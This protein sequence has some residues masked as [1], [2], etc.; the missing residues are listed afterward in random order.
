MA[1]QFGRLT[2]QLSERTI[3]PDDRFC[4]EINRL[5]APATPLT[6]DLIYVAAKYL[7]SDQVNSFG[8]RFP[9]N[10]HSRLAELL[11]DSPV[12]VGHRKDTLPIA[13]NFRAE[14]VERG[15]ERWVKSYFYW[16]RGCQGAE[17]LKA[18]IDGGL[19]KEC[20]IAF[21]YNLPECSICG[22]DIRNCEHEPGEKYP[23]EAGDATCH[24]NY[25]QIERVL[26]SSLVYRGAVPNT[27]VTTDGLTENRSDSEMATDIS[28]AGPRLIPVSSMESVPCD[29]RYLVVPR[30]DAVP[31]ILSTHE[32]R[33]AVTKFDRTPIKVELADVPSRGTTGRAELQI[34]LLVGL[35]GRRRCSR[36]EVE[37]YLAG[38]SSRVTRLVV[39]TYPDTR[40]GNPLTKRRLSVNHVR[41]IPHRI[42]QWSELPQ[43][44]AQ[45]ATRDGVEL[46][47]LDSDPLTD[48]GYL[49]STHST[50]AEIQTPDYCMVQTSPTLGMTYLT[51]KVDGKNLQFTLKDFGSGQPSS[52]K[53]FLA[54]QTEPTDFNLS[55]AENFST[56]LRSNLL[57]WSQTGESLRLKIN[58]PEFTNITLRP[59]ILNR[60]HRML[61]QF[62]ASEPRVRGRH[63]HG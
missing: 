14:L 33:V 53:F 60:R 43:V 42:A 59:V 15:S 51:I 20:S 39:T 57:A 41:T 52:N 28:S 58:S 62:H 37:Q 50:L 2:T 12:L 31:V 4:E 46:W 18:N 6:P 48:T 24:F 56:S 44:A 7:V 9:A 49:Y 10:E 23:G 54:D 3:P 63:A 36:R 13:R 55:E 5:I 21:T 17:S 34:A 61:V 11:V 25:R 30:Y 19:Y 45:I 38:K 26:E 32:G 40:F 27:L 16:L 8:G 29:Q 1:P 47:A 22:D 35:Q